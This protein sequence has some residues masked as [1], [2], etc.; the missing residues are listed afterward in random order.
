MQW[1][2]V[3]SDFGKPVIVEMPYGRGSVV[4]AAD[5][6]FLSNEAL[7]KSRATPL[8]AWVVGPNARVVFDESHLGVQEDAGIAALARRYGMAW[9]FATLVLLAVLFV[10]RRMAAFIPP[11]EEMQETALSCSHTAALEELFLRS[12]A[13]AD[14]IAACSAEWRRSAPPKAVARLEAALAAHPDSPAPAAYNAAVRALKR[15]QDFSQP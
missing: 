14:L 5:S 12:V 1:S 3:Y 13:P 6:Y 8:L 11:P 7:L 4:F 9:A 10:W 2:T 15:R